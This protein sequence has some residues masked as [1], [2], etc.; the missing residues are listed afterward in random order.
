MSSAARKFVQSALALPQEDRAEIVAELIRSLDGPPP[1]A[2][3]QAEVG[4]EWA[5]VIE[6]RVRE[7]ENGEV[8]LDD[9]DEIHRQLRAGT[10]G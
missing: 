9:G 2:Q 8:E 4:A 6:R 3:E 7:V 5:R 10:R 1:S